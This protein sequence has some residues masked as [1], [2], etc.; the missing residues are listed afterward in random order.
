MDIYSVE[1]VSSWWRHTV[2]PP[3]DFFRAVVFIVIST[4]VDFT[5]S[6]HINIYYTV[7]L[8]IQV[9]CVNYNCVLQRNA[10]YLE[11][12]IKFKFDKFRNFEVHVFFNFHICFCVL[13]LYVSGKHKC[14]RSI[15]KLIFYIK[16]FCLF[17]KCGDCNGFLFRN[18]IL[19]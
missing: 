13:F 12:E 7:E 1:T 4:Y 2:F 19:K 6:T 16:I 10:Y 9:M 14:C 15:V 18:K 11:V 8:Y 5:W 3:K 17:L